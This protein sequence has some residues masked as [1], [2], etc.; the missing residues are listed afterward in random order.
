METIPRHRP[1]LLRQ[2]SAAVQ[3]RTHVPVIIVASM[4]SVFHRMA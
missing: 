3:V 2:Q 4:N 1:A